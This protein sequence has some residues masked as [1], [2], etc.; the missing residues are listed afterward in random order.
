M[1]ENST[2][3]ASI[4]QTI[5]A[6]GA[7]FS[8]IKIP[9]YDANGNLLQTIFCP[10]TYGPKEKIIVRLNQDP[11]LDN[12]VMVTLPRMAFEIVSY[13]R[14]MSR[15]VNRNNKIISY[16]ADGSALGTFTPVP[17]N[18][19]INLYLLTK[20]TEDSLAVIE[21]ILPVFMP[22]YV[23]TINSIVD[24]NITQ[25][26][27]FI[28]NGV[29]VNDE[30]EGSFDQTRLVTHTLNFT[31]KIS[32]Y[33]DFGAAKIITRTDTSLQTFDGKTLASHVSTGDPLTGIITSDFW[34]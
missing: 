12:Q 14:D 1:F 31:A 6:F 23:A 24:M 7:L 11:N 29:S 16:R 9:R 10:I 34:T 3:H 18:L 2:Y 19:G 5:I 26:V 28:M 32:L 33:G 13:E 17:F 30:Y 21:Q 22:E 4:K 20:G 8:N 15:G 25:D 27:P